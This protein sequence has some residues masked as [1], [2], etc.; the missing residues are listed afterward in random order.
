MSCFYDN[1]KK[2][3]I[4]SISRKKLIS[5]LKTRWLMFR[6]NLLS[7]PDYHGRIHGGSG[8]KI[9]CR[10]LIRDAGGKYIWDR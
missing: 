5:G 3:L 4:F 7:L 10:L 6:I 1:L 2:G 9:S 8:W